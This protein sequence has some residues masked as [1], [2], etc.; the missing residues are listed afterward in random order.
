MKRRNPIMGQRDYINPPKSVDPQNPEAP[1]LV[2]DS[3]YQPPKPRATPKSKPKR[4]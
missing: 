1:N 3:L 2:P 4:Y